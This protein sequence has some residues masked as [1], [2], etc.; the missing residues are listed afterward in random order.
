MISS[1]EQS[2]A[3][4]QYAGC[5]RAG[6]SKALVWGNAPYRADNTFKFGYTKIVLKYITVT[7]CFIYTS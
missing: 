5:C 1:G 4:R 3:M 6:F 7:Y 2:C